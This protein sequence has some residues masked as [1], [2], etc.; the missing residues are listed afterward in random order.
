M[1][2]LDLLPEGV[3][4]V[5]SRRKDEGVVVN[6]NIRIVV[7]DIRD[8]KVRLGIEAPND[9]GVY[10]GELLARGRLKRD[11][12]FSGNRESLDALSE[13]DVA[14]VRA[15]L[16]PRNAD[17]ICEENTRVFEKPRTSEVSREGLR[18]NRRTDRS[19]FGDSSSCSESH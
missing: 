15:I 8:G 1:V 2:S 16:T 10:R 4:L 12:S 19:T 13:E 6:D 9:V 11:A 17:G 7:V 3:M 5:L 14:N 18:K